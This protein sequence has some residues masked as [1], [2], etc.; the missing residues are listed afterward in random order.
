MF[1]AKVVLK[2]RKAVATRIAVNAA[3]FFWCLLNQDSGLKVN[4]DTMNPTPVIKPAL[5]ELFQQIAPAT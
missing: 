3:I 5:T 2:S 1:A 4:I